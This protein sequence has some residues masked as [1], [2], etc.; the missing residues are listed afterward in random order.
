MYKVL[1]V[2]DCKSDLR[3]MQSYIPWKELGCEIVATAQNGLDGYN[4]AI[5]YKP[6]IVIT[7][8][9]MPVKDG[10]EM[11]TLINSQI[12]NV[13]YIYM[14]CHQSFDYAQLAIENHACAYI[15]KPIRKDDMI[16]AIKKAINTADDDSS[17]SE[18]INRLSEQLNENKLFLRENYLIN[19]LLGGENDKVKYDFLDIDYN[20]E[21][22][23]GIAVIE[24]VQD[25]VGLVYMQRMFLNDCLKIVFENGY[26]L[27]YESNK[28]VMLIE[29]NDE[30]MMNLQRLQKDFNEAFS[31]TVSFYFNSVERKLEDM[32]EQFRIFANVLK[33]NLFES[34]GQIVIVDENF[35]NINNNESMLDVPTLYSDINNVFKKT[36]TVEEF[37][38]KYFPNDNVMNK[39][40][41][42]S[43]SYSV[44]CSICIFLSTQN[45]SLADIFDDEM[46]VWRKL[47][48]FES[49]V[50]VRR[51]I[52]N[53][54]K[55]VSEFL[56]K[57]NMS[58]KSKVTSDNIKEYIDEHFSS[59]TALEESASNQNISVYHAN[60][61]FKQYH[62]M[63]IFEYLV[64]KRMEEAK[65]L[66]AG[67]SKKIYEVAQSVGYSSN[68]YFST[69]FKKYVGVRPQQY[70]ESMAK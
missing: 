44:V 66:L 38:G 27:N 36:K 47:S 54:I 45:S 9:S 48:D 25:K 21:Y 67:S 63:T 7:D 62:N 12:K 35:L 6:D 60:V 40:Y 32:G 29:K 69:A 5:K 42:K 55:G 53:M 41:L 31:E 23:M 28:L 43:L 33:N 14:S 64:Q 20:K 58:G 1:I 2:D 15:L 22:L 59:V 52:I 26:F 8:I 65:K 10:F 68:T 17:K 13:F 11:T 70:R 57:Q 39:S 4:A 30:L 37:I 3:G 51:W 50:D 16:A 24:N 56:A 19:F 18:L 49:I 46:I 34:P 61:I